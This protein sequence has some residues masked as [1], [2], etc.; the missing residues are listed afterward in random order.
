MRVGLITFHRAINYGAVLQAAALCKYINQNI[1]PCEVIDFVP[2]LSGAPSSNALR[3]CLSYGKTAVHSVLYYKRNRKKRSFGRF[4]KKYIRLSPKTYFGDKA[5]CSDPPRYDVYV[6]GSDQILN[7]TLT[8]NS[9]AFYLSFVKGGKKISYASSFGRKDV[10]DTEIEFIGRYLVGFDALS[11]REKSGG[12]IIER[13]IGRPCVNVVDPVFLLDGAVWR[14]MSDRIKLRGKYILVYAMEYS[15]MMANAIEALKTAYNYPIYMICGS[16]SAQALC[17][18]KISDLGPSEFIGVI[19][20]AEMVLTNSFHGTA[21][22]MIFGKKLY[23]VSHSTRN[24]RLENI[25]AEA[26]QADKL[27]G[28][29]TDKNDIVGKMID[30]ASGYENLLPNIDASKKYLADHIK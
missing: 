21:F 12:E 8:G 28:A 1:C 16:D 2:N 4:S 15:E 18:E 30:G 3:R 26:G 25:L 22:S 5:I 23:C 20:G 19:S 29:E 11:V 13:Q 27:I 9:S 14:E 17:G 6:S 24:A 7:T 10:S